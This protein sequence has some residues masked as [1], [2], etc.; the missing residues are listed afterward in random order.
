M[1]V[2]CSQPP[3]FSKRQNAGSAC[4]PRRR[5]SAASTGPI[6]S[7]QTRPPP[8][9][10]PGTRFPAAK[11]PTSGRTSRDAGVALRT[12]A[13]RVPGCC[14]HASGP[15]ESEVLS[16]RAGSA[17]MRVGSRSV[18]A[19]LSEAAGWV[20]TSAR[21]VR[22][23]VRRVL[24]RYE[25]GLRHDAAGFGCVRDNLCPMPPHPSTDVRCPLACV[26]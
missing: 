11:S 21:R 13:V 8:S 23:R 4:R 12:M 19:T 6:G 9:S 3:R 2:E 15:G 16:R 24:A 18:R 14:V 20:W 17:L 10:E 25:L 26:N 22:E 1:R 7:T 5:P